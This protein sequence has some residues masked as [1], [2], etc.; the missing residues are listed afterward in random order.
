MVIGLAELIYISA[1]ALITVH[2]IRRLVAVR[3]DE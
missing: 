3:L 2:V 1:A